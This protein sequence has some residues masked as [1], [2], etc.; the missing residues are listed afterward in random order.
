VQELEESSGPLVSSGEKYSYQK[1]S[2]LLQINDIVEVNIKTTDE[3]VNR[4]FSSFTN[5][6]ANQNQMAAGGQ[7]GG[8][9]FFMVLPL[10]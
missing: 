6:P 5:D 9:I 3:A 2:Y 10:Y 1:E 4:V 8:D 7:G